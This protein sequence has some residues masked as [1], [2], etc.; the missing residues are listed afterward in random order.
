MTV[1]C[2]TLARRAR[3]GAERLWK[4]QVMKS[5]RPVCCSESAQEGEARTLGSHPVQRVA[6][7]AGAAFVRVVVV[8]LPDSL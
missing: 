2:F 4:Q 7:L 6:R 8:S 5:D 1:A 3:D